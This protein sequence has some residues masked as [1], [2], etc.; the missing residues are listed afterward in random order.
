MIAKPGGMR[1][2]EQRA[3]ALTEGPGFLLTILA[4]VAVI[5]PLVFIHELGHY[6]VARLC[7]VH[8]E[9]FSIGFGKE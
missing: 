5:G 8:S 2:V 1:S 4:F 6:W 9:V 3:R 7:G